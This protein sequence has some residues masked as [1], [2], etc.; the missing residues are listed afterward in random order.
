MTQEFND[1]LLRPYTK[2]DIFTTLSQM[3]PCKAPGPDGM[4]AIFYQRF[5][6]IIGDE[7]FSFV[8]N[9]LHNLL[10]LGMLMALILPSSQKL[11]IPQLYMS[12]GLLFSAIYC[13]R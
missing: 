10:A 2:E 4:H 11:R 5:W 8:S 9:I 6:H 13:I 12:L 3:H 1:L 7:V